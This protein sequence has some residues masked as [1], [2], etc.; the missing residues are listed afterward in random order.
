MEPRLALI[1]ES[2]HNAVAQMRRVL[3]GMGMRAFVVADQ[4]ALDDAVASLTTAP[5]IVI[6]RVALPTGSGIRM[7]DE[8]C[9]KFPGAGCL[10]ISHHPLTLLMSAPGF[11]Q[12]AS[13]FLQAEFTDEQFR[14]AVERALPA[15][16]RARF[17]TPD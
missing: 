3:A 7:L 8:T 9:A 1:I 14:A 4:K 2:D 10:L 11:A 15:P 6:A 16:P 12:H 5:S 13:S 17:G